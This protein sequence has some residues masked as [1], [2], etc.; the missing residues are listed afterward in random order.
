[1]NTPAAF[2]YDVF[3]SYAQDDLDW[4]RNELLPPLR[5]AGL[6]VLTERDFGQGD[7][8]LRALEQAVES[9]QRTMVVLTP[10]WL[11]SDWNEFESFLVRTQ[12]PAARARRLLPLLLKPCQLPP[13]LSALIPA[14]F[15]DIDL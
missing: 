12:D 6:R 4:V 2:A 3:I 8:R 10:A 1:M 15:T 14:D 7:S 5:E 9:S 13:R 11:E